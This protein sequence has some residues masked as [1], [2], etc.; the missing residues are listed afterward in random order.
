MCVFFDSPHIAPSQCHW[1]HVAFLASTAS[2]KPTPCRMQKVSGCT[3][4]HGEVSLT[5]FWQSLAHCFATNCKS[6]AHTSGQDNILTFEFLQHL[7]R[8]RGFFIPVVV[9][10]FNVR[11][12][13]RRSAWNS[14]RSPLSFHCTPA[15]CARTPFLTH[16]STVGPCSP[17][18]PQRTATSSVHTATWCL[19]FPLRF[20]KSRQ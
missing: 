10:S 8:H 6:H 14:T 17:H 20:V 16:P 1:A 7:R 9:T 15:H 13:T 19:F 4:Q 18:P 3:F 5:R 12:R 11:I 2:S